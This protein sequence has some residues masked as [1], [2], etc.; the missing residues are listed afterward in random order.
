MLIVREGSD[1]IRLELS[2]LYSF[3]HCINVI[4][5]AYLHMRSQYIQIKKTF[6][7]ILRTKHI[8]FQNFNLLVSVH[9]LFLSKNCFYCF[10]SYQVPARN[11]NQLS[12]WK[13]SVSLQIVKDRVPKDE[14]RISMKLLLNSD[15]VVWNY[16]HGKTTYCSNNLSSCLMKST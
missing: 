15:R 8:Y 5:H 7:N 6:I 13:H 4:F 1:P 2:R 3:I 16:F 9:A 11:F 10:S 12:F 14:S